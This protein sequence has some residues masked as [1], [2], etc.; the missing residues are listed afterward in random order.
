MNDQVPSKELGQGPLR[1]IRNALADLKAYCIRQ[2]GCYPLPGQEGRGY[3]QQA[4]HAID[5]IERLAHEPPAAPTTPD[6][7]A[8]DIERKFMVA[9]MEADDAFQK[10]GAAGTKTWIRD[11][12]LGRLEANGIGIGMK[13]HLRAAQ[14]PSPDDARDAERYRWLRVFAN[15]SHVDNLL[16]RADITSLDAAIDAARAT[17][18]KPAE[19]AH[20]PNQA[21]W[22]PKCSGSG[23]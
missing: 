20:L 14:P 10:A 23:E 12:L 1:T 21:A 4:E 6:E 3:L 19:C 2:H 11:F 15:F 7:L 16:D 17:A 9:V 13:E 8:R 22:C 5:L 18:T